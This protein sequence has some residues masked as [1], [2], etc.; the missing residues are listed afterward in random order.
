MFGKLLLLKRVTD[1]LEHC[2]AVH[3]GMLQVNRCMNTLCFSLLT[4]IPRNK[5]VAHNVLLQVYCN[6]L[7]NITT[8]TAHS[9]PVSVSHCPCSTVL[10]AIGCMNHLLVIHD[11]AHWNIICLP[12]IW[13][14]YIVSVV[15]SSVSLQKLML[16]RCLWWSMFAAWNLAWTLLSCWNCNTH[17]FERQ[18]N[19]SAVYMWLTCLC[20]HK[21]LPTY[22]PQWIHPLNSLF[23]CISVRLLLMIVTHCLHKEHATK[24]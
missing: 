18:L 16:A 17:W 14:I 15:N 24:T 5:L 21:Q 8:K 23:S 7:Y 10:Q 13:N 3:F 9:H 11:A 12:Y 20:I 4:S 19:K 2:C 22:M 1:L 6:H